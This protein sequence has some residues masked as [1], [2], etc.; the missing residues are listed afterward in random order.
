MTTQRRASHSRLAVDAGGWPGPRPLAG[1]APF[2]PDAPHPPP[3][4]PERRPPSPRPAPPPRSVCMAPL[5]PHPHTPPLP[6]AILLLPPSCL[7]RDT[8][9][10][11]GLPFLKGAAA[12]P[13]RP[14]PRPPRRSP[15]LSASIW[16]QGAGVGISSS[17]PGAG[18]AGTGVPEPLPLLG[19]VR[20]PT[21]TLCQWQVNQAGRGVRSHPLA[22]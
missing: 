13:C 20:P 21:A 22:P 2:S 19:Q 11:V 14:P 5:S 7:Q 18:R 8:G 17:E 9:R 12:S 3:A 6:P 10:F 4:L 15:L 16:V 1:Q